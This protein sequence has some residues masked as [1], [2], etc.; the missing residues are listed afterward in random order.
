MIL[1]TAHRDTQVG[2]RDHSN[3][4]LISHWS[5]LTRPHDER[6]SITTTTH[7]LDLII[8]WVIHDSETASAIEVDRRHLL[9]PIWDKNNT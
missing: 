9:V 4:G 2:D 7:F 5:Q 6:E 3:S 1:N 8:G